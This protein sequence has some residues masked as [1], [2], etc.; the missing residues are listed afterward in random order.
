MQ[1]LLTLLLSLSHLQHP[2]RNQHG[3]M[4]ALLL[5][6]LWGSAKTPCRCCC[7]GASAAGCL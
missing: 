3:L 1:P 2:S 4:L 7:Q 6:P 5:L